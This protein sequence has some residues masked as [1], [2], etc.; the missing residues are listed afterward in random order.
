MAYRIVKRPF[1]WWP[2]DLKIVEPEGGTIAETSFEMHFRILKVD[3]SA[4]FMKQAMEAIAAE[5]SPDAEHAKIYA[6]MVQE[7]ADNWRGIEAENGETMAWSNDNLVLLMN[8]PGMFGHVFEA[9][10]ACL[11]AAPRIREGN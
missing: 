10:R 8:E 3:E 1:A 4:A 5:R 9:W 2:V 6:D 11:N 7:I